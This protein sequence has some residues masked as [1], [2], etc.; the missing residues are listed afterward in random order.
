MCVCLPVPKDEVY[1]GSVISLAKLC[2]APQYG[3]MLTL[4]YLRLMKTE[5]NNNTSGKNRTAE[6]T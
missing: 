1:L 6:Q 5:K 4:K 2:S 3:L